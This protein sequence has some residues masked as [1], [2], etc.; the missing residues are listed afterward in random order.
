FE[1]VCEVEMAPRVGWP[2]G[3][4]FPPLA[5]GINDRPAH[6]SSAGEG[7]L[8]FEEIRS[9]TKR[10]PKFP[11]GLL[12]LEHVCLCDAEKVMNSR[13][14]WFE[15]GRPTEGGFALFNLPLRPKNLSQTHLDV[16]V[17]WPDRHG[18][19]QVMRGLRPLPGNRPDVTIRECSGQAEIARAP[20]QGLLQE[21]QYRPVMRL[22][23]L[24]GQD[25]RQLPQAL[26]REPLHV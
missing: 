9:E 11:R 20:D 17:S 5:D 23:A 18:D 21:P 22:A 24:V 4:V 15:A 7:I 25:E 19:R 10:L 2:H 6:G 16:D 14:G 8:R 13:G 26:E 1:H 12:H 3:Q